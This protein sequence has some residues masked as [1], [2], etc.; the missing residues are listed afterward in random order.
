MNSTRGRQT[1]RGPSARAVRSSTV[2][3]AFVGGMVMFAAGKGIELAEIIEV[4][5]LDPAA[6]GDPDARVPQRV[7]EVLWSLLAERFPGEALG[8][9]MSRTAPISVFGAVAHG[10][11]HAGS[12]REALDVFVR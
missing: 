4:A 3:A 5:G 9:E 10:A 12:A 7:V 8:L 2:N 11:R 1:R 6:L